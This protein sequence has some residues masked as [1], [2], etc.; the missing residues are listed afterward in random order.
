MDFGQ[1]VLHCERGLGE[2]VRD[3]PAD[4]LGSERHVQR[5]DGLCEIGSQI[6]KS[7]FLMAQLYWLL[8]W[9]E[10]LAAILVDVQERCTVYDSLDE[11]EIG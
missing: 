11:L 9:S 6:V 1:R 8:L 10:P 7:C 4:D 5:P 2:F 3:L